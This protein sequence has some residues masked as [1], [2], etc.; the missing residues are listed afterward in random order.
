[1]EGILIPVVGVFASAALG[2]I[3]VISPR[4]RRYSLAAFVAP[5]S[6]SIAFLLGAF[7]LADMNPAR[8]YGSAYIPTGSEHDPTRFDYVI[9]LSLVTG[10]LVFSA[11]AA[12]F[13]QR[14]IA[15]ILTKNLSRK[16][17]LGRWFQS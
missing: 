13:G 16:R 11:T 15:P 8:E 14:V 5:I 4:L 12:Y 1:M 3:C 7:W 17:I 2:L 10:T 6:T 9:W